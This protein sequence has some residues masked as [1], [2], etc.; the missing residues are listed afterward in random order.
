MSRSQV[1]VRTLRY[2]SRKESNEDDLRPLQRESE[3]DWPASVPS[4]S[5]GS[6]ARVSQDA[7][8]KAGSALGDEQP[9]L[10]KHLP[11][12][13][14]IDSTIMLEMRRSESAEASP[15]LFETARSG[16]AVPDLPSSAPSECPV[17]GLTC[18]AAKDGEGIR[19]GLT[20]T[21]YHVLEADL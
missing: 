2:A 14:Q 10:R 18:G 17:H 1:L 8:S 7:F 21:V 11:E 20:K 5:S 15:G 4:L 16:V 3:S 6:D 12:A 19:C 13:G 9:V